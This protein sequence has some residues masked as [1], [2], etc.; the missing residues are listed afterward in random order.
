MGLVN[1]AQVAEMSN[2][3]RHVCLSV[4][5]SFRPP[6]R[7]SVRFTLIPPKKT[8]FLAFNVGDFY[9]TLLRKF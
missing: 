7:L 1:L 2:E 9:E 8:I 3:I 4:C 6:Y 5:L